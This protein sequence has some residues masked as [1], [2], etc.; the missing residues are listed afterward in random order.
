M[1]RV[2]KGYGHSI[3]KRVYL[4]TMFSS[5]KKNSEVGCLAPGG[6]WE[7][8]PMV[9]GDGGQSRPAGRARC[10]AAASCAAANLQIENK[11]QINFANFTK[12]MNGGV[13]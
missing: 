5:P 6:C 7:C 10:W 4:R 1:N 9:P 3:M 8:L 2:I 12:Q 13:N 11:N